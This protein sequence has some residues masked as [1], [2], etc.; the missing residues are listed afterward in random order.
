MQNNHLPYKLGLADLLNQ[1]LS[2]YEYY[3]ALPK[4]IQRNLDHLDVGSLEEMQEYANRLQA[5]KWKEDA[6]SGPKL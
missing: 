1:D 4:D 3:N 2:C 6:I 5:L